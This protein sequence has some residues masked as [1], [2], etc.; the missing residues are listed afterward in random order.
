MSLTPT[1]AT[2]RAVFCGAGG[3]SIAAALAACSGTDEPTDDPSDTP[4]PDPSATDPTSGEALAAVADVP[5]GG[6]IVVDGVILVQPKEGTFKAFDPT[7]PHQGGVVGAPKDGVMA[8]ALHDSRF[9]IEDG[10][11]VKDPATT[12][13]TE[14]RV[15]VVEDQVYRA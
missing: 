8:C 7:C 10:S 1:T 9:S 15:T 3:L 11:V 2:R 13:L 14:V 4:A 6:G 12:G 5:V